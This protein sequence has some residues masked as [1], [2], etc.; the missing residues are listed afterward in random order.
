M[1]TAKHAMLIRE[2]YPDVDVHVFYI[3][4]R[5]PGKN[6][7]EFYRRAAEDYGVNYIKGMVGKL[8]PPQMASCWFRDQI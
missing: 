6:F 5:T 2:K 4:V 1:Y 7:D 3:D 8:L